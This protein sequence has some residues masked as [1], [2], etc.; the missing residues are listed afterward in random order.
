MGQIGLPFFSNGLGY[1]MPYGPLIKFRETE[2]HS[3]VRNGCH[4]SIIPGRG[5]TKLLEHTLSVS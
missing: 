3:K 1:Q 4:V 2:I 5:V